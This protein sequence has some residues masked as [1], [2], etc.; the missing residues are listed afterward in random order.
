MTYTSCDQE[1]RGQE[2]QI[3][4]KDVS[5]P[6][7]VWGVLSPVSNPPSQ[8]SGECDSHSEGN[9]Y[10]KDEP[11]LES[12][13]S[14]RKDTSNNGIRFLWKDGENEKEATKICDPKALDVCRSTA[15]FRE[16]VKDC[17][18]W[19]KL[20]KEE[21]QKV[22]VV[23]VVTVDEAIVNVALENLK[24]TLFADNIVVKVRQVRQPAV[25]A[26][27]AGEVEAA[28]D[29]RIPVICFLPHNKAGTPEANM[30]EANMLEAACKVA[31]GEQC[32]VKII[33]GEKFWRLLAASNSGM[34]L[35]SALRKILPHSNVQ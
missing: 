8:W 9:V 4:T 7:M 6:R 26:G 11:N 22:T 35:A 12:V 21:L 32:D 24:K 2:Q 34:E 3:K 17:A 20:R 13:I 33:E 16:N 28:C 25:E 10:T 19:N 30:L 31:A 5:I 15:Y 27:E 14:I 18:E 1:D 23:T 29:K